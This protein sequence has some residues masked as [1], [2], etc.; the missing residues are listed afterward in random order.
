M[1]IALL[2]LLVGLLSG[3]STT[4]RPIPTLSDEELISPDAFVRSLRIGSTTYLY[5]R[6]AEDPNLFDVRVSG[7]RRT[8][9]QGFLDAVSTV[10]GCSSLRVVGMNRTR[11]AGRVK[12]TACKVSQYFQ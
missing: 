1:R 5:A 10:Y 12:G 3:C 2:I 11:T 9:E 6:H 4:D 8:T 7:S